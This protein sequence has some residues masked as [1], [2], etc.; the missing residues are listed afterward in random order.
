[1][2]ASLERLPSPAVLR[3]TRAVDFALLFVPLDRLLLVVFLAMAGLSWFFF[4]ANVT[5]AMRPVSK[6]YAVLTR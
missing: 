3:S 2:F 4:F 5:H 1:M 6:R